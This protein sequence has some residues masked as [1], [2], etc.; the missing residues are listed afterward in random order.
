LSDK[1][2]D[3]ELGQKANMVISAFDLEIAVLDQVG[4]GP[5]M[6]CEFNPDGSRSGPS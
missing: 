2:S 3:F 5:D 6:S 1:Y 4:P